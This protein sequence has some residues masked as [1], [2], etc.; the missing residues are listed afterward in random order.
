MIE[1][2]GSWWI[3]AKAPSGGFKIFWTYGWG[4]GFSFVYNCCASSCQQTQSI[5]ILVL[6]CK[7]PEHQASLIPPAGCWSSS[8]IS[9]NGKYYCTVVFTIREVTWIMITDVCFPL[10]VSCHS[11]ST[12]RPFQINSSR[13]KT[14]TAADWLV[15][16]YSI[17]TIYISAVSTQ[18]WKILYLLFQYECIFFHLG[19]FKER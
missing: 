6:Q 13:N 2:K 12:S 15:L 5:H 8:T 11:N 14:V 9:S 1:G 16:K 10:S 7:Y 3:R 19:T 18:L 17:W 4:F